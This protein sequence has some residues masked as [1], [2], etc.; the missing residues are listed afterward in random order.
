MNLA[1][2]GKNK[3]E[4]ERICD[5]MDLAEKVKGTSVIDIGARDG[6]IS[7]LLTNY[8]DVVTALDILQ[9]NIKHKKIVCVKGD[10]TALQFPTNSF[11]LVFCTEVL[12]HIATNQLEKA[13][14]EIERV[15]K[16]HILIGVPYKQD[17]RVGRTTCYTCGKKNPPWG[18]VNVFDE[19]RLKRLFK[20][21]EVSRISFVGNNDKA[22][23]FISTFLMDL[24]GNP[25]GTYKQKESCIYCGS[26]LLYP[27]ERN[28]LQK[29]LTR[30]ATYL[31]ILQKQFITFH[32]N[33]IHMLLVKKKKA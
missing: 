5:L 21:T 3:K 6:D 26:K 23:N 7:Q 22:T 33:W 12:E 14:S 13:C 2:Y 28:L 15:A 20:G 11:D 16:H 24:S 19:K 9:P 31:T 8:F 29:I 18:H 27:P 25:Y 1:E 4:Q 17:I 32:P 10:V 30:I